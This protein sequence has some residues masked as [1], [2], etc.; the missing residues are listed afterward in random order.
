MTKEQI[1]KIAGHLQSDLDA[2]YESKDDHLESIKAIYVWGYVTGYE[3][4]QEALKEG[5][6]KIVTQ[7]DICRESLANAVKEN[8]NYKNNYHNRLLD[9]DELKRELEQADYQISLQNNEIIDKALQ[10]KE[11]TDKYE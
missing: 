7:L 3:D 6:T 5:H 8:E 9:I 10:I 11:L 4:A 2:L 1:N